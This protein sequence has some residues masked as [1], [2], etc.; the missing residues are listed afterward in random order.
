MY[1]RLHDLAIMIVALAIVSFIG[2]NL[3]HT[4]CHTCRMKNLSFIRF[5]IAVALYFKLKV[6]NTSNAESLL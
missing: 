5:K 2:I 4:P 3:V 1:E 6:R